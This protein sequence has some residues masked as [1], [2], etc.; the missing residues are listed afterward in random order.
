MSFL[1]DEVILY[2][3][4]G[5]RRENF[6]LAHELGHWLVDKTDVVY[7]T[8]AQYDG[9]AKMLESVCDRIA[10]VLLLPDKRVSDILGGA[11]VEASHVMALYR[12]TSASLHACT[13]ALKDRFPGL[14]AVVVLDRAE[15]TV[16][17]ASVRPDDECGWPIV[18]P[19]RGQAI[20]PGHPLR[21]VR[22]GG[23]LRLRTFWENMWGQRDDFYVDA[24]GYSTSI[25]AVFSAD[26]LWQAERFHPSSTRE[27]DQRPELEVRCCGQVH[28]IR[29]WPCST[30]GEGYCPKCGRCR[31]DR[32]TAAEKLCAGSC[33]MRYL[34]HLLVNGLCENCR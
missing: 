1:A 15:G 30:C 34:P 20:P 2:R 4:T 19:W 12:D 6:T 25:I 8:L 3:R 13:I 24:I 32:H 9:A 26:D 18:Y 33:Y 28:T 21:N 16:R 10:R 14:G 5:N 7:D 11:P 17:Y 23:T 31:C 22:P 29:G 27:F